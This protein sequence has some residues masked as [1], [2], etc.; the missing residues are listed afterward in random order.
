MDF[1]VAQTVNNLPA[2]QETRMWSLDREDPL[3]KGKAIHSSILAW[4]ITWTEKPG[5]LQTPVGSQRARHNWATNTHMYIGCIVYG[6]WWMM[7]CI[8]HYS[9]IKNNSTILKITCA[10]P[11]YSSAQPPLG[12]YWTFYCLHTLAVS[13][14][15]YSG[16]HTVQSFSTLASLTYQ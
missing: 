6:F 10:S 14:M 15:S 4:R 2:M 3:Q 12:N 9:I 11:M 7:S 8:P 13:G 1:P 5:G 16:N